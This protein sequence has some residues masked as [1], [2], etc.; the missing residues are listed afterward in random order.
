[1]RVLRTLAADWRAGLAIIAAFP[2]TYILS[3]A[4]CAVLRALFGG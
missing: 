2:A 3:L 1:M 4:A